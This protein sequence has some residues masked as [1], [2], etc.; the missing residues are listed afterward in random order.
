MSNLQNGYT[1]DKLEAPFFEIGPKN[2]LRLP[3]I[4][5]LAQAAQVAAKRNR[6]AVILTVPA[7]L[8]AQVRAAVPGVHVFAQT[9]DAEEPGTSVGR[10]IAESLKDAGASGV[11]L[12][13]DSC[14]LDTESLE[15]AIARAHANGL[16]TMVCAGNREQVL[17]LA[18]LRPTVILFEP[19]E[20]IGHS[21]GEAR[22]WIQDIDAR[23]SE[24]APEVL[25]MHAGGVGAPDD[26]R[27]IMTDGAS[28]T[29]ATSGVL[30]AASPV[31]A[32]AEFVRAT[33]AGFDDYQAAMVVSGSVPMAAT[34]ER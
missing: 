8:I 12:N 2:L 13:H 3:E 1:M 7:P 15:R 27:Q 6:V 34:S 21:G 26:A 11:M 24:L 29:G 16:M 14:P 19:P 28:G 22:P 30:R 9:M 20:L 17:S 31:A 5:E 10:T 25:M 32:V 18:R 4:I 33:R 23:M